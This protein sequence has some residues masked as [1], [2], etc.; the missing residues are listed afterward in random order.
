MARARNLQLEAVI[1]EL[2]WS[3]DQVAAHYRRTAAE[4]PTNPTSTVSRVHINAWVRGSRPKEPVPSTLCETFSRA[5]RRVVTL[6]DIGMAPDGTDVT[7]PPGWDVDTVTAL[8]DLGSKDLDMDRRQMLVSTAYSAAGLALPPDQW[9]EQR[10]KQAQAR[11]PGMERT[12]TSYDVEGIREMTTFFSQ[13]DQRRGG[14]AGRI[15]LIAYRTEVAECLRG[16]AVSEAVRRDLYAAAGEFVYLA[17]WTAFDANEHPLAQQYFR[18]ATQLAAEANDGPL[19]GHILRAMAH[20]AVDLHQPAH[21]LE[22]SEASMAR[23][24]YTEATP[25]ERAL[26]GVVHARSLAAAGRKRDAGLALRRAEDDLRNAGT[27]TE[28]PDRVFFFGEASLAHE[29]AC[30]LRDMGHLERAEEQFHRSVRTRLAQPF[31]RTHVVTLGYLGSVQARRGHLDEAIATW[32]KAL[33][34]MDGVQSGRAREAVV[35]MRRSLSPVRGRGG[36]AAADLDERARD[37]LR[38]VG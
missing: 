11:R 1:R 12:V 22:F 38:R 16:R 6:A 18:L 3:Q 30:A 31:A 17:G 33:D 28:E 32:T 10:L 36:S 20:Q 24:R 26:L 34:S 15:A 9:W 21:A 19:A 13:R 37:V 23:R 8:V 29:T 35:Q 14:R 5:L 27:G 25:R 2:G 7:A 4:N